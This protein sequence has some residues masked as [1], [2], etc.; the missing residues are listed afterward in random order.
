MRSNNDPAGRVCIHD[1]VAMTLRA[2]ACLAVVLVAA[3]VFAVADS[4]KFDIPAQALVPA[5]REFAG[6]S[7]MQLLYRFDAVSGMRSSRVCGDLDKHAALDQLL[8]GTGLRVT[9]TTQ[10]AATIGPGASPPSRSEE[11]STRSHESKLDFADAAAAAIGNS[12]GGSDTAHSEGLEEIVVTAQRREERSLDVPMSINAFNEAQLQTAG[13]QDV[14]GISRLTPGLTFYPF[15]DG[16][17]N[18]SLRGVSSTNGA[19]T[20]GIYI[21]DTPI[22]VRFLGG[23]AT[24]TNPYPIIFDL[25][26][27]EVLK[28]PQGTLFGAGSEGGAVRFITEQPSFTST[29]GRAVAE[30]GFTQGGAPSYE[31]A[32]ALGGPFVSDAVAFR[33]SAYSRTDGG[34]IDRVP[35]PNSVVA[36][37]NA[38]STETDVLRGS[39][40]FK[41]SDA[42][43]ITPSIF[44]QSIKRNDLDQY[45]QS[46]SSAGRGSYI[47]GQDLAQP[48]RD[49]FALSGVKATVDLNWATLIS[50]TSYL[51]RNQTVTADYTNYIPELLGAPYTVGSQLGVTIPTPMANTQQSLVQE[52][53]LQSNADDSSKLKWLTGLFFQN[54][55]QT[56]GEYVHIPEFSTLWTAIFGAPVPATLPGNVTYSGYDTARDWQ[57]AIFGQVDYHLTQSLTATLGGRFTQLRYNYSNLQDGPLNEGRSGFSGSSSHNAFT[58]RAGLNYKVSADTLLYAS[59]AK[60]FRPGGAN[61]PV[62]A[63]LCAKDLAPLNFKQVPPTYGPDSLWSY[64]LGAKTLMFDRKLQIEAA[65]FYTNWSGIQ[66]QYYLINCGFSYV[67]NLGSA[68]SRGFEAKLTA[69]PVDA[70]TLSAS[71]AYTDATNTKTVFSQSDAEGSRDVIIGDGDRLNVAPWSADASVDYGFPFMVSGFQGYVH[72]DY[73][74]RAGYSFGP[75]ADELG[76]QPINNGRFATRYTS[77]RLG[78]RRGGLDVS[79]FVNNLFNSD[80]RLFQLQDTD[81]SPLLR[82]ASFRPRTIGVTVDVHY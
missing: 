33:L 76:Y 59:A 63:S 34:W 49:W 7:H 13:V 18:I 68:T 45:W 35:F 36:A 9:F 28:G 77:G 21:D 70:L 52:V 69:A 4:T 48:W 73:S 14:G 20:T 43:T 80:D 50:N 39:L 23:G 29:S 10:D 42:V 67:T 40:S 60:G 44:Y 5:L 6:Q 56:A 30:V 58:P 1:V 3:P 26:R 81:T 55:R 17:T 47:N 11:T 22:Q 37:Q 19:A 41:I 46:L 12:T 31:I 62:P 75:R 15:W 38:N 16:S 82:E 25:D 66:D 79:L 61:A 65:A 8:H 71:V 74:F 24:T 51:D 54:T 53:R 27:V 32:G 57:A 2:A 64:E 72:S 78:V